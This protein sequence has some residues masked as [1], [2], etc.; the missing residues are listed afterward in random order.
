MQWRLRHTA[1]AL[2]WAAAT[3]V[4]REFPETA[5]ELLIRVLVTVAA[6]F[7]F[8]YLLATGWQRGVRWYRRRKS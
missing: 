1:I 2:T 6:A 7:A 8:T 5:S 4:S 3:L